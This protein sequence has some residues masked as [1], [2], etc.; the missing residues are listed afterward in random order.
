L[1]L[2][3]SQSFCDFS[4]FCHPTSPSATTGAGAQLTVRVLSNTS[5]LLSVAI[6]GIVDSSQRVVTGVHALKL[7]VIILEYRC[8]FFVFCFVLF[9]FFILFC[10]IL[11]YYYCFFSF[12][13]DL[14]QKYYLNKST[15]FHIGRPQSARPGR[16]LWDAVSGF[17][18]S[19]PPAAR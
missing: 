5:D 6:D 11:F 3:K 8:F 10:F 1:R 12:C 17:S 2:S 4:H 9:C 14:N 7:F 16:C 13:L 15:L 18:A 19:T